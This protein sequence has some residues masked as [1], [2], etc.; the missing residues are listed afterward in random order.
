MATH[1]PVNTGSSL[2][3]ERRATIAADALN[4]YATGEAIVDVARDHGISA[5]TL[6]GLLL[7][8]HEE[9]WKSIQAARALARFERVMAE[10][11]TA[12]DALKIARARELLKGA[13]WEL[14][15]VLRRIYGN[16]TSNAAGAGVIHIN[17]GI[18]RGEPSHRS[19]EEGD[20]ASK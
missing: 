1:Y 8:E 19:L 16:E 2:P 11:E 20:A 15:R 14:E 3:P 18:S 6:Y 17:I 13:M 7:H 12:P 9:V 4:R 10:L 5:V